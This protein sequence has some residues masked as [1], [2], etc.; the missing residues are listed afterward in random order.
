MI[1]VIFANFPVYLFVDSQPPLVTKKTHGKL[2]KKG[3]QSVQI[4]I[5]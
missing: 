5:W 2:A 3:L 4:S 1:E